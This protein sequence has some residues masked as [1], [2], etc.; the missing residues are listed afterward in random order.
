MS[1]FVDSIRKGII[2]TKKNLNEYSLKYGHFFGNDIDKMNNADEVNYNTLFLLNY[3]LISIAMNKANFFNEIASKLKVDIENYKVSQNIFWKKINE[4]ID[5]TLFLNNNYT[6]QNFII[7]NLPNI[8]ITKDIRTDIAVNEER[9]IPSNHMVTIASYL[10]EDHFKGINARIARYTKQIERVKNKIF[11]SFQKSKSF[12]EIEK[13]VTVFQ[14]SKTKGCDNLFTKRKTQTSTSYSATKTQ[15][16]SNNETPNKNSKTKSAFTSKEEITLKI[17]IVQK[18][19]SCMMIEVYDNYFKAVS[20]ELQS[21]HAD[22]MIK[23]DNEEE[24]A[25][26]VKVLEGT[27]TIVIYDRKNNKITKKKVPLA[28]NPFGYTTF[29]VGCRCILIGDKVYI[30][31]GKDEKEQFKN[32]LIYD[33]RTETLK[34]IMDFQVP[35]CYH[36]LIYNDAFETIMAIGGEL[37]NTVEIFDPMVSRWLLLP[38]LNYPRANCLFQ[39]DKPRGLMYILFGNEGKIIDN[40]YSDV[41]EYLDLMNPKKGWYRLDYYNKSGVGI[42][43]YLNVFPLNNFLLLA[44]GGEGGRDGNKTI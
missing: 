7:E 34:R 8:N 1:I 10:N 22:L 40:K 21:S 44:Y 20:K 2:E 43:T 37:N 32:V 4:E 38:Q 18:Y 41:I 15:N 23:A 31:G 28:N 12:Q 29:P 14:A 17:P 5:S 9:Y 39:F 16:K 36:S 33:K 19:F 35:R 26:T 24:D 6:S 13:E 3:D 30:T 25:D 42:K 11:E 27:N